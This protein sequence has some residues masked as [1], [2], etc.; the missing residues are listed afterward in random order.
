MSDS[1]PGFPGIEERLA[2]LE[3]QNRALRL[4]VIAAVAVLGLAMAA[5]AR[6]V[7]V[8]NEGRARF[9]TL[10]AEHFVVRDSLGVPRGELGMYDRIARLT[11]GGDERTAAGVSIGGGEPVGAQIVVK[12][13]NYGPGVSIVGGSILF[14]Q[15]F[16]QEREGGLAWFGYEDGRPRLILTD[17]TGRPMPIDSVR[18]QRPR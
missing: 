9:R 17:S 8:R 12:Q 3:S 5:L 1:P 2:R 15:K 7:I 13:G 6:W 16:G 10:E 18:M 14:H 4:I 11:L